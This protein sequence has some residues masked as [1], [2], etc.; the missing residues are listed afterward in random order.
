MLV[1]RFGKII[2]YNELYSNLSWSNE[3]LMKAASFYA[4]CI[5][6]G[7]E[8]KEAYSLSYMYATMDNEPEIDYPNIYIKKIELIIRKI[9]EV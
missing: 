7:Y 1:F 9:E 2:E 8:E 3:Q 4:T 6:Y 5:H